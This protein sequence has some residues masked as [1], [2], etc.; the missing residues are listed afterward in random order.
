MRMLKYLF[1]Q[2]FGL[3]DPHQLPEQ[4]EQCKYI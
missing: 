2:W 1:T 3:S 4:I